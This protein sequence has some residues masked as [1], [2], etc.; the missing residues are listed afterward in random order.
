MLE[1]VGSTPLPPYIRKQR[2]KLG[3]SEINTSDHSRYNTVFAGQAGSV[4]APTAGLHFTPDLLDQLSAMGVQ[5]VGV[6]LHVGMGTFAPVRS[7]MLQDHRM[8]A[9]WYTVPRATLDA[10]AKARANGNKLLVIGTTTVRALESMPD[11]ALDSA[12]HPHGISATTSLFIH[13]EAGFEFRFTDRLMTNFHL[14][15]STLLAMV[16]ALPG[17]GLTQL[18]Q[19]YEQAIAAQY[20]FYSYGD[21]MLIV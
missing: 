20:R 5:R 21:A 10:I 3:Q 17:M 19:V 16:A 18:M 13:P 15:R 11:D 7:D 12:A 6:D 8:H 2:R 14:P 9:E 1:R 4:A